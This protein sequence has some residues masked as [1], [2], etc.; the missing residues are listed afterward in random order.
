M[1]PKHFAKL[2]AWYF[3]L[4]R[5][6]L[7]IKASYYSRI[8][9]K[10]VWTQ[11][12]KPYLPSQLVLA[13]QF[14]LL[15]QAL[16]ADT[17]E[18]QHHVV[19]APAY[20]DR[21]GMQRNHKRGPPPPHWLSLVSKLALEYYV[22]EV[23]SNPDQRQDLLGL[24]QYLDHSSTFPDRLVAAPTR[25]RQALEALGCHKNHK[26]QEEPCSHDLVSPMQ[27]W[28]DF[29]RVSFLDPLEGLGCFWSIHNYNASLLVAP[30]QEYKIETD[31]G[32]ARDAC[33]AAMMK[34]T[35]RHVRQNFRRASSY[36]P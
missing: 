30:G 1:E 34:L 21:V 7:G 18:P 36:I 25:S 24:K 29:D 8:P 13:E 20:K 10:E 5:R 35:Q 2:D 23:C 9:N 33:V 14:R 28:V 3:T 15:L 12:G 19:F 26:P 17:M 31:V 27:Y 16:K 32:Q 6:V 22:P 11:A 4:L